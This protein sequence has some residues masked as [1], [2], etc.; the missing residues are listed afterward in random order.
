MPA[1]RRSLL[2]L[3]ATG[4]LA[5]GA[6]VVL[7]DATTKTP[8]A[9]A[10]TTAATA[11]TATATT[12]SATPDWVNVVELGADPAG[13][14]DAASY[15]ATAIAA[16]QANGG[17]VVYVPAGTYL[18][19]STVECYP[20][21]GTTYAPVYF[22]GD[23]AWAT[24]IEFAGSGD[25]F[26]VY[27][28]TTYGSRTKWGGGF[29]GITIDGAKSSG[30]A[31]GLHV[32]DLLQYEL[33]LTVQN[34]YGTDGIGVHLDNNYYWTEQLYGR[35]YA[36]NCTSH[37]V[38][39]WTSATSSTS[40]GSFERCDLDIY[41]DQ[42]NPAFDGL[43]LRNGAYIANGSLKLR[44][45]F[46]KSTTSVSSAA[47]R[48]TGY[49]TANGYTSGSGILNSMLDI[50]VEGSSGSYTPQSIYFDSSENSISE[51]YGALNFGA[52]GTTFTASNNDN[53]VFSFLGQT[54]GDSTLPG[55]WATYSSGFPAGITGH[56][57]FKVLPTGHEV[58][59]SWALTIASGTTLKSGSTIVAVNTKFAYGDNK[60]IPGNNDG[61]GLTGN[62]YAPAYLTP[63][64]NFQYAGPSYVGSGNS[65]WF[66]QGVYTLA[67]G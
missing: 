5:G 21:S 14:T 47:L 8:A 23:G 67:L 44:G 34:F 19:K 32:G 10:T 2:T 22:V 63:A 3:G 13:G 12:A 64:G 4:V 36:Q 42:I 45:N 53:N 29:I 9:A 65:W 33:D 26:R 51:C 6:A 57:A 27:D 25:C 66:G 40:S 7:A 60:I 58:M 61:G 38:F 18:I 30:T 17:G 43:V 48:L 49:V 52:A 59:V 15:F 62:V 56:V 54:T 11:T 35:I 16:V 37:V 46:G 31:A 39:D 1:S 24:V 28:N 55:Q 20:R 41:I 50:G